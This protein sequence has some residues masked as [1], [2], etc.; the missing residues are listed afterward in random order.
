MNR[1]PSCCSVVSGMPFSVVSS[2]NV[3]DE[4]ALHARA[5]VAPDPD[6]ERVVELAHLLDLGEQPADVPVRVL[7]VTGVDLHL[8][9]VQPLLRLTQGIPLR[10]RVVLRQLRVVRDNAELLLARERLLADSV[11]ALVEL[12]FVLVRPLGRH[13]VGSVAAP[14]RVVHEPGT[15][16]PLG[17]HSPQPVDGFLG[18][19]VWEVVRLVVLA[20]W[21]TLDLLVLGDQR[22]VLARLAAEEAPV[23][24][25]PEAGRPAVE[26]PGRALLVVGRQM[27]LADGGGHIAVLLQDPRERRAVAGDG[28]VVAGERAREL[29]DEAE[30]D[31]VLVASR[32]HRRP[33]WRAHRGDVE[34]V[35][36]QSLVGHAREVR[37]V[38]RASE[39]ARVAKAG[40]VDQHEQHV[41]SA[42]RR[43]DVHR[44]VPVRL[45]SLERLLRGRRRRAAAGS[46]ASYGL[47]SRRSSVCTSPVAAHVKLRR[48]LSGTHPI[49]SREGDDL[50]DEL[51][52]LGPVRDEEDRALVRR[53]EDVAEQALGGGRIE[54]R[55]RLVEHENRC[56]STGAPAR[57]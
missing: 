50:V 4:R 32:E 39:R 17:A 2:L 11:P 25:E 40:I 10:E 52:P 16:R 6:H 55:G 34:A 19:V 24:V 7:G 18:H 47:L 1:S 8:A 38:D 44:L 45:R 28:G 26:G 12:A 43:L 9:R 49:P 31:S 51:E 15:A 35:V 33:R 56:A 29:G 30:A 27:P 37:R 20:L 48:A 36:A 46:A 5:V 21:N 54:M 41:R 53:F 23:V 42:L 3:P 57:A 14:G 22:V 13:L